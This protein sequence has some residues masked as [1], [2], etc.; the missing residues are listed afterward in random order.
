[1]HLFLAKEMAAALEYSSQ[2]LSSLPLEVRDGVYRYEQGYPGRL[3]TDG[4]VCGPAIEVRPE[5]VVADVH[6]GDTLKP[7][8][9]M[10]GC[11]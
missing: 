3:R 5:Q 11:K 8:A 9:G 1:V 6:F 4:K 7:T 10:K 2:Q